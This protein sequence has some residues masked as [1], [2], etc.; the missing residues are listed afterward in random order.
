[1]DNKNT[2]EN[3]TDP[4]HKSGSKTE[5]TTINKLCVYVCG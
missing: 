5:Q 3:S 4:L 1:M 2:K